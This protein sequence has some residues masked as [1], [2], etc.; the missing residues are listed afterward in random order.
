MRRTIYIVPL[1]AFISMTLLAQG[2]QGWRQAAIPD[3]VWMDVKTDLAR[4]V[5]F[6]ASTISNDPPSILWGDEIV[7]NLGR[8]YQSVGLRRDIKADE[9][10]YRYFEIPPY[11]FADGSFLDKVLLLDGDGWFLTQY[12]SHPDRT[13]FR[14]NSDMLLRALAAK[15]RNVDRNSY[16]WIELPSM[17]F[18]D[19]GIG[20]IGAW[21]ELRE[22][23]KGEAVHYRATNM[24][25]PIV[26]VGPSGPESGYRFEYNQIDPP[27]AEGV[28]GPGIGG[29]IEVEFT[30]PSDNLIILNGYVDLAKRHLYKQNNRLKTI[31]ID[32]TGPAFS[33]TASLEDVVRFHEIALPLATTGVR[34]TILDVYKGTKYDD[35]CVSKI[36]IPQAELRPRKE[37][38]AEIEKAL[39]MAG[40]LK[41]D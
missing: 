22:T 11:R 35:T 5:Q 4:R 21:S 10:G 16:E 29:T 3:L 1:Y 12:Y 28:P 40:Y 38:E 26:V 17:G 30:R 7:F 23:L 25:H 41:S 19:D 15:E 6:D 39:R 24:R 32:S 37:Y 34:L 27:W 20:S 9:Q 36:F 2:V 31:R 33:I 18:A 8:P 14:L 13:Y